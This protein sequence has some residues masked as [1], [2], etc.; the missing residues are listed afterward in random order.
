MKL[1]R[2]VFMFLVNIKLKKLFLSMFDCN[3]TWILDE[4]DMVLDETF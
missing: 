4:F 2:S 1:K 3:L